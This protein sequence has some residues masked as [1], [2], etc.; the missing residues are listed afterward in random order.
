MYLHPRVDVHFETRTR[1]LSL[2]GSCLFFYVEC[3]S[4]TNISYTKLW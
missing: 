2:Y 3:I 1:Y 4:D